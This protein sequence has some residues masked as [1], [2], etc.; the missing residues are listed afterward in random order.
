MQTNSSPSRVAP[1]L[2]I[3]VG[4]GLAAA[5]VFAV[6]TSY[7]LRFELKQKDAELQQLKTAQP[8]P[9]EP[10]DLADLQ[11]RLSES[12][13]AL[14][15]LRAENEQLTSETRAASVASVAVTPLPNPS[16][17]VSTN[18]DRGAWLDRLRQEDPQRYQRMMEEREQ[19][20]QRTDSFMKQQFTRL[21]E[22]LQAAQSQDE[23]DLVTQLTD[24]LQK[25]DDMR[26]RWEA[27][28]QLPEEERREQ[29]RELGAESAQLYQTY[30]ELRTQDR[31]LQLEHLAYDLGY[32]DAKEV[33]AF[34]ES[35]QRIN[36]E[37]DPGMGRFMG[38]GFGRGGRQPSE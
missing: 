14:S 28:R 38:G 32:K 6:K 22:R 33:S 21:D 17:A 10:V 23:V 7:E 15:R 2:M 34:V 19:R 16:A 11:R 24:T 13:S 26:Q 36:S 1:A 25:M 29:A 9:A 37:T 18:R 30:R 35:V 5:T 12:E 4:I 31:Q 3:L 27:L 20:R 8:A